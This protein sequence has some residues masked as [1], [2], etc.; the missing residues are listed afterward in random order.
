[1]KEV[2]V[3]CSKLALSTTAAAAAAAR[4]PRKWIYGVVVGTQMVEAGPLSQETTPCQ[5]LFLCPEYKYCYCYQAMPGQC[6]SASLG[7]F[8]MGLWF[9][10]KCHY[11][12]YCVND[13][14]KAH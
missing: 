4:K 3:C 6:I 9:G 13:W 14:V 5:K 11:Q 8:C 2:G 10:K 1:M 7:Y 12:H